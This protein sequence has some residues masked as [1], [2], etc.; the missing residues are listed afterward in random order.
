MEM[1]GGFCVLFRYPPKLYWS[2]KKT[3]K[4]FGQDGW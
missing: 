4:N 1:E 3:T 2:Y